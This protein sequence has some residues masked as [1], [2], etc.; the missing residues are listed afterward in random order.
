MANTFDW[1][2]IRTHDIHKTAAFYEALFG[3]RVTEKETAGGTAVWLFDTG[4][5]PRLQN[6]KRGGMWLRPA[7]APLGI[8]VYIAV[9][10]IEATL[11]KVSEL[12]GR[13]T[14]SKM[15]LGG[16]YSAFFEDPSGNL[17]G[18]YQDREPAV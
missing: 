8:V 3:W 11:E 6:L 10:D 13:V 14:G 4:G 7:G 9:E 18:L 1:I 15:D 16:G 17:L 12:G 2:E 5:E